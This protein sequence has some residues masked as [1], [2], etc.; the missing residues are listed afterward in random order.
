MLPLLH[1]EKAGPFDL[2]FIDADK[3]NNPEYLSWALRL[4]RVGSLIIGDNVVR[5]GQVANP[6]SNDLSVQGVRRFTELVA[7]EPRLCATAV[8]TVGIKGYDGFIIARVVAE[9]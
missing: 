1:A 4:T 2:I 7:A 3:P 8:Q 6:R 9:H 5:K